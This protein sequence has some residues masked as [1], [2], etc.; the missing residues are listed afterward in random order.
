MLCCMAAFVGKA[1]VTTVEFNFVDNTYGMTRYTSASSNPSYNPNPTTFAE[2]GVTVTL[3]GG[4][5]RLWSDGVRMYKSSHMSIAVPEGET[6]SELKCTTTG[7]SS[8]TVVELVGETDALLLKPTANDFTWTDTDNKKLNVV[9]IS[10]TASNSSKA[11]KTVS[12]TYGKPDLAPDAVLPVFSVSDNDWESEATNTVYKGATLTLS[13]PDDAPEGWIMGYKLNDGEEEYAEEAVTLAIN[14]NTTVTAYINDEANAVVRQFN[15]AKVAPLT[16]T[17]AFGPVAE[18]TEA[19]IASATSGALLYGFIGEDAVEGAALPYSF[20]VNSNTEVNVW[21]ENARYLDSESL[22][23]AFTIRYNSEWEAVTS[24]DMLV[25]GDAVTF[26]AKEYTGKAS[27]VTVT[28][29]AVVMSGVPETGT[30]VITAAEYDVDML[31]GNE[32]SVEPFTFEIARDKDGK[33]TFRNTDNGYLTEPSANAVSFNESAGTAFTVTISGTDYAAT[34]KGINRSLRYNPNIQ[35]PVEVKT[36]R[37]AFYEKGQQNIYMYRK[38]RPAAPT[39]NGAD[40]IGDQLTMTIGDE[41]TVECADHSAKIVYRK[42][43][44]NPAAKTPRS[45]AATD[46]WINTGANPYTYKVDELGVRLSFAALKNGV[47][48]QPTVFAIADNGLTTGLDIVEETAT[49]DAPVEY[50]NLQGVK[51][52]SPAGGLYIRRQGDKVEKV[53]LR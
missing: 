7:G 18:G 21:A 41:I 36:A 17:P 53:I 49:S 9:R 28:Y 24:A 27:G 22:E 52:A 47:Y 14:A 42:E 25:D 20:T 11:I 19:V 48:S 5:N 37:F 35:N 1:A 50:Y 13:A 4:N 44:L 31:A 40:N 30:K 12:V 34:V 16:I 39:I 33:I 51:V 38:V 3:D 15:V 32:F 6:I 43:S 45:E 2:D 23:G 29:P 8:F 10:Y 46:S 26:T